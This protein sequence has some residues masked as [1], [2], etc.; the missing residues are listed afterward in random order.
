M[1]FCSQRVTA[2]CWRVSFWAWVSEIHHHTTNTS[3]K[4]PRFMRIFPYLFVE[5]K[6]THTHRKGIRKKSESQSI[7][8]RNSQHLR[9]G[10][11]CETFMAPE[12]IWWIFQLI[13]YAKEIHGVGSY[14]S[15]RLVICLKK[16][17][18]ISSS[19]LLAV[20]MY[21]Y[22]YGCITICME[23]CRVFAIINNAAL[24]VLIQFWVSFPWWW[25]WYT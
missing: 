21:M 24:I 2:T 19:F 9:K 14:Y 3:I 5:I 7:T 16:S 13:K 10:N 4:N 1:G 11:H 25:W 18:T 6:V 8:V 20:W 15:W 23:V 22:T 17:P 12:G